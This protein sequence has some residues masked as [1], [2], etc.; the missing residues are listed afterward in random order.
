MTE[1][2]LLL[3]LAFLQT[4][5]AQAK[6]PANTVDLKCGGY[7][8]YVSLKALDLP[9][10][11][12]DELEK[13]LGQP[14]RAGYSMAQL[15]KTA[16]EYGAQTL[17]VQTSVDNLLRRPGRF[18]C[19]ALIEGNHFVNLAAVE[20]GKMSIIDTPRS[21]SIPLDTLS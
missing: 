9:V 18:A 10:T 11:S 3:L 12:Y 2:L 5:A 7:C 16:K 8:L 13:R 14:T 21:E 6:S 20:D 17:G 4:N 1:S 15:E 19:I